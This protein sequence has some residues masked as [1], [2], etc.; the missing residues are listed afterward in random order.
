LFAG[1]FGDAFLSAV[2]F[3]LGAAVIAAFGFVRGTSGASA[4]AVNRVPH[5]GHFT[6]LPAGTGL[7]G[8][9]TDLHFGQMILET[10]MRVGPENWS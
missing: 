4:P 1:F 2:F 7:V 6:A 10:A 9:R 5:S 3:G 8:F